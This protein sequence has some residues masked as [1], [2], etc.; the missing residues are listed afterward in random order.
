[1]TTITRDQMRP[2]RDYE[3]HTFD[4]WAEAITWADRMARQA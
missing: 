1:M 3:W 2:G 4:T